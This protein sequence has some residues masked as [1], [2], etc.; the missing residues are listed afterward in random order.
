VISFT[1]IPL[2]PRGKRPDTH[3]IGGLGGPK[4]DLHNVERR[5]IL[6]PLGLE[7][8]PLGCPV[9][10]QALYRLRYHGFLKSKNYDH[11]QGATASNPLSYSQLHP[12]SYV[13]K[14]TF[15]LCIY[16]IYLER[17]TQ[18]DAD[19]CKVTNYQTQIQKIKQQNVETM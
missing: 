2:Y 4:T 14:H 13:L 17:A 8:R 5:K 11:L 1:P 7:L 16:S 10:S 6:P 19:V 12:H 15:F 3:W 9:H 18:F